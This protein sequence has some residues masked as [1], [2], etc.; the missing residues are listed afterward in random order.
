M[1][2]DLPKGN[3]GKEGYEGVV[4]EPSPKDH[5]HPTPVIWLLEN[6]GD[7]P[8]KLN[9]PENCNGISYD[10]FTNRSW[11]LTST[12]I[13]IK[14]QES[15]IIPVNTSSVTFTGNIS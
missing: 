12:G 7:N 4:T 1:S 2:N 8:N 9:M 14:L 13:W 6:E 3:F 11:G 5:R 10:P 15:M